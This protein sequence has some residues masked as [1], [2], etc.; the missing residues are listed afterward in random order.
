M[1][2]VPLQS[3]LL[4]SLALACVAAAPTPAAAPAP[5]P[6]PAK[7]LDPRGKVHIPIGLPDTL[8]TLKTFVEAEGTF[9]PGVGS[10]GVYFWLYD[11]VD[12]KLYAP[13]SPGADC[14]H[15]LAPGGLPLPWS[16]WK[17]GHVTVR[18]ELCQVRRPSEAGDVFVVG[19]RVELRLAGVQ[20]RDVS[21]YVAL[22]GLGPAGWSVRE[23][24]VDGGGE[25]VLSLMANGRPAVVPDQ[26]AAAAGVSDADAIGEVA[27]AGRMPTGRAARSPEGNCSGALRFDFPLNRLG[28]KLSFVCPVLPGRRAVGHRW[29][30]KSEWAQLD[31]AVPNP[32]EGGQLQPD[33]G[34]VYYRRLTADTLFAEAQKYWADFLGTAAVHTPDG[35]WG[36]AFAAITAHAA[37]AMNEGAPD[38]TVVN[39]NVFNRDGIYTTNILHKVGRFDLAEKC[40]D[41]FLAHPFNGRVYPEADN[42]GQI[43]WIM[44]EHWKFTRDRAWLERVYP[45]VRKLVAMIEYYRT[46]PGPHWVSVASLDF[47]DKLPPGRRQKLEPGRCDGHHPEYTEAFDVAG[48][49]AAAELARVVGGRDPAAGISADEARWPGLAEKLFASYDVRFGNKLGT[50]YGSYCVLWPCRLYPFDRGKAHEQFRGVGLQK[51]QSWRYFPLATAHQGLLAG[52]RAAAHETINLHL[53]HEQMADGESAGRGWY[54]FDE[55]G[56]SGPGG[57]HHLRTTWDKDVAMPHGWANAELHLL[58]RDSLV[59]EDGDKLVLLAGVPP[60]W[61]RAPARALAGAPAGAPARAPGAPP[62]RP[63][64]LI[65]VVDLPTHFGRCSFSVMPGADEKSSIIDL[66]ADAA[67]PGGFVLCLPPG[68]VA[69]TLDGEFLPG[70]RPRVPARARRLKIL[71]DRP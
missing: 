8:D 57:W 32:P 20:S 39:Y 60:Q 69:V 46:T 17:A 65:K 37:L 5:A 64:E 26:Q 28:R 50:D 55:G 41:Y 38:V 1:L 71:F 56:K 4:A 68:A 34:I 33:A 52:N 25:T 9:S 6:A 13:T 63:D 66:P 23:M 11:P 59:Y 18:T 7:P 30:G 27:T 47:G 51:P 3:L 14:R 42:P 15:G 67:P 43:L 29:D 70:A 53:S 21:L 24:G 61:L 58:I 40:I 2:R 54:A 19:W 31:E 35:R 44:G 12:K 16:E 49:R 45:S 10:Y 22:R 48:L 62:Q 36:E